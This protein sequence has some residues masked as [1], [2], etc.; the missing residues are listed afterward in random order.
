MYSCTSKASKLSSRVVSVSR[1][2]ARAV[3]SALRDQGA[4]ATRSA[5]NICTFAPA[6]L[7]VFE[8]LY[9]TC[10]LSPFA[11]LHA[12]T[13]IHSNTPVRI[14][15]PTRRLVRQLR[16]CQYWYF[17]TS[18]ASRLST[19]CPTRGRACRDPSTPPPIYT[20]TYIHIYQYTRTHANAHAHARTHK[21][22]H[23]HTQTLD[24]DGTR[25]WSESANNDNAAQITAADA[26]VS[27]CT[28]FTCF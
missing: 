25:F 21:H 5:A 8:L 27:I 9:R 2:K 20:H 26:G 13:P 23:T 17:G 1:A 14:V 19:S 4:A 22:T 24:R 15:M 7:S 6:K 12:C 18:K 11:I 16:S 10:V 3:Q 28:Q